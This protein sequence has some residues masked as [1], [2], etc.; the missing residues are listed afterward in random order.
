MITINL[1]E[2]LEDRLE[3]FA[4]ANNTQI[5][6][7]IETILY[8]YMDDLDEKDLENLEE[9]DTQLNEFNQADISYLENSF[10]FKKKEDN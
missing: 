10:G 8:E 7:L 4:L 1:D 6:V 5:D 9:Y 3:K 2:N